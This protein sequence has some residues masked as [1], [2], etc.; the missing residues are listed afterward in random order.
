[1]QPHRFR[2]QLGPWSRPSRPQQ[3]QITPQA[4]MMCPRALLPG[5]GSA[6]QFWQHIYWLAFAEAQAVVRPSLIERDLLASW[7]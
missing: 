7:N 6:Q 5:S 2:D 3:P 4:F 1:M